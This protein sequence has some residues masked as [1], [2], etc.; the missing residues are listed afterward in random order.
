[1]KYLAC[2]IL[3]FFFFLGIS[4]FDYNPHPLFRLPENFPG[5][6]Y[7]L[8]ANPVTEKGFY[9]GKKLFY[10]AKLS[11]DGIISC[12][13]C[14]QQPSAFTH[15]G[16]PVSHGVEGRLG[17]RNAPSIVN[18]LWQKTFFWDGGVNHL[19]YVSLNAINNPNEMNESLDHILVKLNEDKAYKNEFR[20]AFGSDTISSKEFLQAMSQY[21]AALISSDSRYDKYIRGDK[22]IL[23]P[24]E[25]AGL[26]IFQEKCS[27]CHIPD[28]FTDGSYRNTGVTDDYRF[29]K[30]R[31]EI[32][33][34]EKDRGKYKVPTLR[35]IMYT[36]P[37]MHDGSIATIV[38]V[39][40]HYDHGMK[41]VP[42][43]DST[44]IQKDAKPGIRISPVEKLNL[45]AFLNTL[46]DT[47]FLKNRMFSEY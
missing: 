43:L 40:D 29:D 14:H 47:T 13:F 25:L 37:Y 30:G 7:D 38:E 2:L 20:E 21:L 28:L 41:Q 11:S 5:T 16:H 26:H 1:M 31:E 42:N 19:D 24:D 9:L 17:K 10:D 46:T 12:G 8:T 45:L 36:A 3:I 4:S 18:V 44:F 23:T 6:I 35:N 32:T 27:T 39:L 15:H 33:L 34:L 22:S